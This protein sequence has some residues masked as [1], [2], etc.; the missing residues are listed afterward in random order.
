MFPCMSIYI[1]A[2]RELTR[3]PVL[4]SPVF[5]AHPA[6]QL[7]PIMRVYAKE[8]KKHFTHAPLC[9]RGATPAHADCRL[10]A[11]VHPCAFTT[12][13]THIITA[14]AINMTQKLAP[15]RRARLHKNHRARESGVCENA[16]AARERDAR[17]REERE[18]SFND[19]M[20]I[21]FIYIKMP[22]AVCDN[23]HQFVVCKLRA[24]RRKH[25]WA[26][27]NLSP[28]HSMQNA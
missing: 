28:S 25:H 14:F 7:S 12:E 9:A 26:C 19:V 16:C 6:V 15:R 4:V 17:I 20:R 5:C 18:E 1:C 8:T 22:A 10:S 13:S 24:T 27:A 2:L 23:F 3:G 11:C 21:R